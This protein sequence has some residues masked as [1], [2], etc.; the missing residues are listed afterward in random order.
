MDQGKLEGLSTTLRPLIL[1][2]A[3]DY[4]GNMKAPQLSVHVPE[5]S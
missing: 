3:K 2:L 4:V 5:K 1:W